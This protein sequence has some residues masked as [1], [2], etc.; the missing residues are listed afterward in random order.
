MKELV[1]A[2]CSDECAGRAPGT[3]GGVEARRLVVQAL[4]EAGLSAREQ[5]IAAART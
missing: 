5:E 1:D 2:L 4:R 3:A